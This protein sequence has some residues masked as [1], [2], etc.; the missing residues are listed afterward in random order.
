MAM[1]VVF[2]FAWGIFASLGLSR[3]LDADLFLF[4]FKSWRESGKAVIF[5]FLSCSCPQQMFVA[6]KR[7][8][9]C[10]HFQNLAVWPLLSHSEL[11]DVES[12]TT[13]WCENG[14]FSMLLDSFSQA[15][16]K[17]TRV[18]LRFLKTDILNMALPESKQIREY[19]WRFYWYFWLFYYLLI[20]VSSAG[21]WNENEQ[22][23]VKSKPNELNW[24][25]NREKVQ[26]HH[27]EFR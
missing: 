16:V 10:T 20:W 23:K 21:F 11:F 7:F 15:T 22:K 12:K 5:L 25:R 24:S 1:V 2:S 27:L 8:C 4:V 18:C 17:Q 14:E 13:P 19:E 6:W 3:Q 26:K 9:W